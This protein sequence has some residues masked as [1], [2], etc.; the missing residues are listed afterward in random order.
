MEECELPD[1]L[2]DKIMQLMQHFHLNFSALDFAVDKEGRFWF[3]EINA[4]GNWLWMESEFELPICA[5]ISNQLLA[6]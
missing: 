6:T 5:A 1:E 3:L 4:E 2:T